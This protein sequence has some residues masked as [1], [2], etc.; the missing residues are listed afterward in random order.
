MGALTCS[1]HNG[2][3]KEQFTLYLL[4]SLKFI[5]TF[6][7]LFPL[8]P[9]SLISLSKYLLS[10]YSVLVG[11]VDAPGVSPCLSPALLNTELCGWVRWARTPYRAFRL[12][13]ELECRCDI[14]K[15]TPGSIRTLTSSSKT[16]LL[17]DIRA[18]TSKKRNSPAKWGWGRRETKS[19]PSRGGVICQQK[20]DRP[21]RNH[22]QDPETP[23][24]CETCTE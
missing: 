16:S 8:F 17:K 18:D 2:F 23:K 19:V 12:A 24:K 10:T 11:Y 4:C 1:P 13:E 5:Y 20:A 21:A 14:T 3:H 7:I 9:P 22:E 15:C 6:F